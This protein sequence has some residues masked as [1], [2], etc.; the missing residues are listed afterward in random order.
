MA[1]L[2]IMFHSLGSRTSRSEVAGPV[3]DSVPH[4]GDRSRQ[5]AEGPASARTDCSGSAG[6]RLSS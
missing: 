5:A 1:S 3:S 6:S 4:T 2:C